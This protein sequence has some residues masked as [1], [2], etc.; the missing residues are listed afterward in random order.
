MKCVIFAGMP[1]SKELSRFWR[2]ADYVIAADAG[3]ENARRLGIEPDLLLGDYDSAPSPPPGAKTIVL[4]AEKDDTDT[5]FAARRAIAAG[6][7]DVVILGGLGGRLDHTLANLQTL[8][9]LA[10]NGVRALLADEGNEATVLLPGEHR[11]P[12]RRECYLSIF[13]AGDAARG[14]TLEGLK[15][16]LREATVT[17]FYPIGVSNEFA[18]DFAT[19]RFSEGTLY[20]ILSRRERSG[21]LEKTF[22]PKCGGSFCRRNGESEYPA[23]RWDSGLMGFSRWAISRL[24]GRSK[25]GGFSG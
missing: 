17:G 6:A 2:D 7:S 10:R 24:S 21:G 18:A 3:Y 14:V 8:A 19:V 5:Y 4:P 13:S 16:P 25:T 11:I 9:F 23:D 15:Y 12:A 22:D 1:V 20:L